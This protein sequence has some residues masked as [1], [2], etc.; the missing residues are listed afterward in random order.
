M[1]SRLGVGSSA[2]FGAW[3]LGVGSREK[4]LKNRQLPSKIL[5]FQET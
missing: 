4:V 1:G 3:E 5:F 2:I